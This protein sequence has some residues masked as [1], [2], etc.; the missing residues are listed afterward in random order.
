MIEKTKHIIAKLRSLSEP[1][2]KI[3]FLAVMAVASLSMVIFAFQFTRNSIGKAS[4]SLTSLQT[5]L[6]DNLFSRELSDESSAPMSEDVDNF[7]TQTVDW[8]TYT[9]TA[10][11]FSIEYPADMAV[12]DGSD[13]FLGTTLVKF[14]ADDAL[15][16]TD[17]VNICSK[18]CLAVTVDYG[19]NKLVLDAIPM[20]IGGVDA[21][22]TY[23]YEDG[24]YKAFVYFPQTPT[25]AFAPFDA[26]D[27]SKGGWVGIK[28]KNQQVRDRMIA[29]FKFIK[30]CKILWQKK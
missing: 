12:A 23:T 30:W 3:I 21:R 5:P 18:Q 17:I 16:N 10:S 9:D 13:Q 15:Q 28:V 27:I 11:G 2:K 26:S 1:Q 22:V 6:S 14:G 29:T 25:D 4:Q 7:N 8:K 24:D 19:K 20:T